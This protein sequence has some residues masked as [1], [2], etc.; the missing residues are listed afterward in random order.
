MGMVNRLELSI[1][2]SKANYGIYNS[3]LHLIDRAIDIGNYELAENYIQ[4][5]KDFQSGHSTTIIANQFINRVSEDLVD[6]YISKGISQNV[7]GEYEEARYCFE[8]AN[9]VCHSL[10]KY[11]H[12]YVIKHG[13]IEARNGL[14]MQYVDKAKLYLEHGNDLEAKGFLNRAEDLASTYPTQV[15][16]VTDF[17]LIKS[18]LDYQVYLK[19]ISEGKRYLAEKNYYM[20]YYKLL[21]ALKLE[22]SSG[23]AIYE[24]LPDL[25]AQAAVPYLIDQCK[26][27][28]VKVLKNNIDEAR[29]IYNECLELQVI[30]GLEFEQDLQASLVLLNNSIF[31]KQCELTADRFGEMIARCND[32]V[33]CGDFIQANKILDESFALSASNYYCEFDMSAM[34]DLQTRYRPAAQYQELANEAQKALESNDHTRF[35]EIYKKMEQLS[36]GYEVIRKRIEP[37]PLY[38]LFSIK[39]NLAYLESSFGN[40]EG[41]EECETA[42][43]ILQVMEAGNVPGK[44]AK[45]IQQQLAMKMAAFD[46][47]TA[48]N[49][50]PRENVNR[51]TNGDSWFKHFKKA[52]LKSW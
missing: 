36:Q 4:K 17:D 49:S 37:L 34:N 33:E 2:M 41:K 15:S 43:R 27:G 21:D 48:Y 19:D 52:Y 9:A 8:Q 12:D 6:L 51:Y 10:G 31:T 5:A 3:Y 23:F 20:A 1:Q 47:A 16:V 24:P 25:F 39:K 28:E 35:T 11:N 45:V 18:Q 40:Y 13:L 38:Y 29:Y 50:D 32:A 14:Y 30:H 46:K 26:L 22:E 7:E 42:L 44:D